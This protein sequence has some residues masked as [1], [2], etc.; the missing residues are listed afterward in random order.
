MMELKFRAWNRNDEVMI[1][2]LNTPVLRNGV[3]VFDTDDIIM[4]ST[5]IKDKNG[6]GSEMWQGDIVYAAGLGNGVVGKNYWGEWGL[7][8]GEDFTSFHDLIM[9][10]DLGEILGNIHQ[11]PELLGEGK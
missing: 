5:G 7:L 6:L 10:Q 9:E 3:L 1:Y 2:D 11:N 8:H 4:Q